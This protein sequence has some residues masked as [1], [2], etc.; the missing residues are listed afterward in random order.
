M[1]IHAIYHVGNCASKHG[2]SEIL[3]LVILAASKHQTIPCCILLTVQQIQKHKVHKYNMQ[4]RLRKWQVVI[5]AAWQ[6]TNHTV[7]Y[8]L[9]WATNTKA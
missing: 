1:C 7:L 5:L 4:K 3:I 8:F 9:T 6:T 2:Q